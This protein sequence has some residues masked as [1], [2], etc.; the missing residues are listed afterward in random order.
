MQL[1]ENVP[2]SSKTTFHTGGPAQYFVTVR[3]LAE[4]REALG[5]ARER[6]LAVHIL[7]GGSNVLVPD[8]GIRG[9]TIE[10]GI[11]GFE[12]IRDD[13]H[14][15]IIRVGAG[16]VFDEIV[17]RT[18]VQGLWG[19]ENL[20]SIPGSMGATPI[21]NVG[22]Y[23]VEIAQVIEAVHAYDQ[24]TDAVRVF[25]THACAFGY[26][27]SRFKE[28]EGKRYV[29]TAVDLKLGKAPLR[30]LSYRDLAQHFKDRDEATIAQA[31]IRDAVIAIRKVKF[32]DWH[33]EGT[34][35]SFFKNPIVPS[36]VF[37]ALK[38]Q[39]PELPG[40]PQGDGNMVKL[41]LG[42]LLDR[43]CELRGVREGNV[44]TY[45]A[46]ALVIVNYGNATTDEIE[47]FADMIAKRVEE[48]T[49][50]IIEREVTKFS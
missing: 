9:L 3:S 41:P 46:Q 31:E 30:R 43:V 48:R 36:S 2:L 10:I 8:A 1:E 12:A 19:L 21:Q 29:V 22:A 14:H 17:A 27:H 33:K 7:G 28:A 38:E 44:G 42:W 34:A 6:G 4:L 26:R 16:E 20:S 50:I 25:D 18:V 45:P 13:E 15:T 39:Y 35:G 37:A 49:H 5:S 47:R 24:E 32:P 23:G 11:K 40:Y